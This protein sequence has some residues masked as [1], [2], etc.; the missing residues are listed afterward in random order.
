MSKKDL[1]KSRFLNQSNT[2]VDFLG[3]YKPAKTLKCSFFSQDNQSIF[4]C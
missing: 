1:K 4:V 3:L 2:Q